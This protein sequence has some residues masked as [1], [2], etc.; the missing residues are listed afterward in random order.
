ME[1]WLSGGKSD[2]D[3]DDLFIAVK[4]ESQAVWGG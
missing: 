4:D 3:W 2:Q 1:T